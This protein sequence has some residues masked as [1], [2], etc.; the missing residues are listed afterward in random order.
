MPAKPFL[1]WVGGKRQLLPKLL[2][3]FSSIDA[4]G[5]YH[6]PFVGGGAVFFALR[7]ENLAG[8]SRLTDVNNELMDSYR[9]IRDSVDDVIVHL[10]EHARRSGKEYFYV[11]RGQKTRSPAEAAARLIFLN[12]TCFNGL[13]RVNNS[14][15]FNSPWGRNNNP[16]ICDEANLRAVSVALANSILESTPF[17]SV[18]AAARP[19]D[20]VYFDPPYVPIGT[21]SFTEYVPGGFGPLEQATLASVFDELDRKG[22]RVVLSNSDTS[23]LR[24]LYSRFRIE[25]VMARRNVN[26]RADR[27]GPVAELIIRNF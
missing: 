2:P 20:L 22:V 19:G 26:T 27:R 12:K 23:S 17:E 13:Y 5:T 16:T 10:S 4:F 8:Q 9:A 6:E 11:V 1:K 24:S 21:A 25:Q 18:R 14:G 15:T 3:I 7:N